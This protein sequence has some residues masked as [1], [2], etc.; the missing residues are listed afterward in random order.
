MKSDG[1]LSKAPWARFIG[2]QAPGP[3]GVGSSSCSSHPNSGEPR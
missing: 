3:G 1:S 2:I